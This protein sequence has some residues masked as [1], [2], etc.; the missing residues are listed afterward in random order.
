M[1]RGGHLL[2]IAVTGQTSWAGARGLDA[3]NTQ[4]AQII[5]DT[6]GGSTFTLDGLSDPDLKHPQGRSI[7]NTARP[8]GGNRGRRDRKH[9]TPGRDRQSSSGGAC[10]DPTEERHKFD[11]TGLSRKRPRQ[12]KDYGAATASFRGSGTSIR[13][14][15]LLKFRGPIADECSRA[16]RKHAQTRTVGFLRAQ[17]ASPMAEPARPLRRTWSRPR[18]SAR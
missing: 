15:Q 9:T 1:I 7:S 8:L 2:R 10:S 16:G 11:E 12:R 18:E 17:R 13:R 3:D 5:E 6:S 14:H 4:T